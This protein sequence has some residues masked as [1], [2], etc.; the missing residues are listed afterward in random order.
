MI[1]AD[2][3]MHSEFSSDSQAPME[4]MIEKAIQL[5]YNRICFTDH[6][7]YNYPPH[8]SGKNFLFQPYAYEEK[9]KVLKEKYHHQIKVLKGIEL[10]LQPGIKDNIH[11]LLANHTFDFIIGSTHLVN[12]VDPYFE[13][14][15]N[16]LFETCSDRKEAIVK[17]I[18]K[19]FLTT[20]EQIKNYDEFCVY[21]HLDY[22]V[23]YAPDKEKYYNC[24][25]YMD[26]ID[27]ILRR[28]IQSG[29]GI[30]VNTSGYKAGLSYPN[31]HVHILKRYKELGGEILTIGSDAHIPE[32]IGYD[33]SR[34]HA[35]LSSLGIRY[36]TVFEDMKPIFLK[37]DE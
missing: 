26:I 21:G 28:L 19:Y 5:N 4:K 32:H 27:E 35:L 14:Y 33:F 30:E 13:E 31:P 36:Y 34:A 20:L 1:L 12:G 15:W 10:G 29:K 7:D 3:H 22:I 9:I 16:T 8:V 6:M 2:Y 37:I 11:S 23:R 18:E 24:S 17:G 25:L